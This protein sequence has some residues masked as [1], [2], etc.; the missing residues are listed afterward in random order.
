MIELAVQIQRK[1]ETV[2]RIVSNNCIEET[3]D[4]TQTSNYMTY[5][6]DALDEEDDDATFD[7][8]SSLRIKI[9]KNALKP[10]NKSRTRHS[11]THSNSH[12]GFHVA[13]LSNLSVL[14]EYDKDLYA[15]N[16]NLN[17]ADSPNTKL[18]RF[19][20]SDLHLAYSQDHFAS[21]AQ[22]NNAVYNPDDGKEA[23][24]EYNVQQLQ[25]LNLATR[26]A[27]MS[28]VVL[29]S[30][31]F[32]QSI[33]LI[34]YQFGWRLVWFNYT[35]CCDGIISI[36]AV[37]LQCDAAQTMYKR[38]F[39]DS[40]C[41][42]HQ[43]GFCMIQCLMRRRTR[44]SKQGK[45]QRVSKGSEDFMPTEMNVIAGHVSVDSMTINRDMSE[46]PIANV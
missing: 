9:S 45:L 46:E 38:L 30:G 24:C 4:T 18:H 1:R 25:L 37:Y 21:A 43:C 17:I 11:M 7:T 3:T 29:I 36:F 16:I 15:A 35:W 26:M 33:W 22:M 23:V 2:N 28:F 6:I 19:D 42:L 27:M 40:C 8:V 44:F 39:V 20:T 5:P 12:S 32:Y 10:K 31:L 14:S 34:G 13:K 41:K